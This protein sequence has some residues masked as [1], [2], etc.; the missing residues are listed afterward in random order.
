MS[1][2]DNKPVMKPTPAEHGYSI[3]WHTY[4]GGRELNSNPFDPED[5]TVMYE[6]FIDGWASAQLGDSHAG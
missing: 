3:G 4:H 6:A 2:E 5:E 1:N